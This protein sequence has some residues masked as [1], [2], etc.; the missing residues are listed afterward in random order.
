[1]LVTAGIVGLILP[2][3][4]TPALIAGGLALWP[5]AFGNWSR[6]SS[7]TTQSYTVRACSKSIVS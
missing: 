5:K 7:G 2:G 6:G 3:P 4:G 1:M